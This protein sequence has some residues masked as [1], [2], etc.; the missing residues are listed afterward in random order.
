MFNAAKDALA[1]RTAQVWV[2]NLIARYGK[3]Q[4]LKID[5]RLK[6]LEVSCLLDGEPSPITIRIE[7][8]TVETE[9]DKKFLRATSFNCTR[10]WL[11]NLLS[12]LGPRQR[13]ELPPWATAVL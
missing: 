3:V 2:N 4:D 10:P 9:G 13:I 5:S 1:S 6:T 8:Y 7:N 12:D 11:Q